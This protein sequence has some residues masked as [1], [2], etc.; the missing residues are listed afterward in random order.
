MKN[1]PTKEELDTFFRVQLDLDGVTNSNDIAPTIVDPSGAELPWEA[2]FT[3]INIE[4]LPNEPVSFQ[5]SMYADHLSTRVDVKVG[6][7]AAFT[8]EELRKELGRRSA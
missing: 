2:M 8:D 3:S 1:L 7:L 6:T 5:A 4:M